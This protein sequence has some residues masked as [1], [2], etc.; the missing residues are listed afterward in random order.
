MKRI[1]N[2]AKDEKLIKDICDI[3]ALSWY[4]NKSIQK[5]KSESQRHTNN[6]DL[7]RLQGRLESEKDVFQKAQTAMGID[8]ETIQN[9]IKELVV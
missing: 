1:P 3:Y 5:I 8:A 9:L 4:S 2:R 6:K 7:I